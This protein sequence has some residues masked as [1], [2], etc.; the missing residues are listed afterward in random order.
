[1]QQKTLILIKVLRSP[2]YFG[3]FLCYTSIEN[4]Y[5]TD[6]GKLAVMLG[7]Q[8]DRAKDGWLRCQREERNPKDCL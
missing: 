7:L 5:S 1:M 4:S 2:L 8:S 3:R 6:K